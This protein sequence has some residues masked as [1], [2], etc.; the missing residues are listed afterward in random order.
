MSSRNLRN[1]IDRLA[2]TIGE[3][4][5]RLSVCRFHGEACH[6]G[7]RWPLPWPASSLDELRDLVRDGRRKAGRPLD[8]DPR[9][10]WAVERHEAVPQAELDQRAREY[11]QLLAR[12]KAENDQIEAQL[13]EERAV[14]EGAGT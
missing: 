8:P 5:A 4:G 12:L 7:A 14:T 11:E 2:K 1:R 10:L 3:Q 13:C 6:M 9:E